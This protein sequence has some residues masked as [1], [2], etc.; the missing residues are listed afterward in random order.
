MAGIGWCGEP[1]GTTW[2]PAWMPE[3]LPEAA[4]TEPSEAEKLALVEALEQQIVEMVEPQLPPPKAPDP[5]R[6]RVFV[7][8]RKYS[9][10]EQSP[11]L[12]IPS[13]MLCWAQEGDDQWHYMGS[14]RS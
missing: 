2:P 9:I 11:T 13:G 3:Y 10:K 1:R 8:T 7:M 4:K 12:P 14:E 5:N 6:G